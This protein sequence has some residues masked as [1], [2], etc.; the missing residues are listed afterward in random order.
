MK[1][2]KKISFIS[3]ATL[4]FLDQITKIIFSRFQY[5]FGFFA[6]NLVKNEGITFGLLQGSNY[7]IGIL[8]IGILY[9]LIRY[10]KEF[11]N[12]KIFYFLIIAGV[13][14]NTLDRLLRGH[15]IDFID[16]KFWPVFNL[17]DTY[18]VIGVFGYI[19]KT[20]LKEIPKKN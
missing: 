18:L 8:S 11:K 10:E 20:T 12:E 1:E 13:I 14:G 19:I 16:F 5:D 4:V 9:L 15:V 6:F 17:A 7:I 2:N 3:I